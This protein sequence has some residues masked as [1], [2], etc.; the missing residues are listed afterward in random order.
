L[1]VLGQVRPEFN[2]K[3][4][5]EDEVL[6]DED[7]EGGVPL[8]L[9]PLLPRPDTPAVN[10]PVSRGRSTGHPPPPMG[11]RGEATYQISLSGGEVRPARGGGSLAQ[12]RGYGP[13]A[14]KK[15]KNWIMLHFTPQKLDNVT[16]YATKTG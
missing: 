3:L 13:Y 11:V 15:N 7:D 14:G 5:E 10:A 6:L 1:V 16:C 2:M 9:P 4:L 8:N 12:W